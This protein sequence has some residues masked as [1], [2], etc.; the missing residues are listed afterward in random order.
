MP[1][2]ISIIIPV[3]NE[4]GTINT[5]LKKLK[6]QSLDKSIEV[7]IVDAHPAG[8][9][10]QAINVRPSAHFIIKTDQTEQ[11]RGLQMNR[12]AQ[13][14]NSPALLFLHADTFLP[15]GAFDAILAVL[16][17]PN[18]VGG[19][20]DL[21]ILSNRWG[22]RVIETVASIRSRLTRLPYCDQA[23]FLRKAYFD[24][25][26]GFRPFPIMEDVDLMRRIKNCGDRIQIISTPVQTNPRRW[27]EE[28][29]IYGT[30]RNWTLMVLFLA[31]VS[32]Q[33][34]VKWYK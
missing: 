21:H 27:E 12:G 4:T 9:T 10:L 1:P 22:Y 26:G 25:L 17:K 16:K 33:R 20:F 32:P 23:I 24:L 5:T 34:L 8:T 7:I 2:D 19:A 18:F 6:H 15:P 13:L 3:W 30:L 11:G 29:L 14:A 31:G 28:G